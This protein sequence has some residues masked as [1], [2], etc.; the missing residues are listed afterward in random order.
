MFNFI[1]RNLVTTVLLFALGVKAQQNYSIP[2]MPKSPNVAA[3]DRYGTFGVNFYRGLPEISIP[4]YEIKTKSFS[5]P[6]TLSYHASGIKVNDVAS[7]VGL[8]W[9]VSGGAYIGR[10]VRG[11]AD[12]VSSGFTNRNYFLTPVS[13]IDPTTPVGYNYLKALFNMNDP[14]PEPDAFTYNIPG[15]FGHFFYKDHLSDAVFIPQAQLKI[16]RYPNVNPYSYT[17]IDDNGNKYFFGNLNTLDIEYS[18]VQNG[19]TSNSYASTY[20]V[21]KMISADEKDS[22]RYTYNAAN[23]VQLSVETDDYAVIQDNFTAAVGGASVPGSSVTE[24]YTNVTRSSEQKLLQ[25]IEYENGKIEFVLSAQNR[26]D[27]SSKLLDKINIYEKSKSGYVLLKIIDF[28]YGYFSGTNNTKRLRLDSVSVLPASGLEKQVYRFTYNENEPLPAIGLSKSIDYWGYYNGKPNITLMPGR[29]VQYQTA[30]GDGTYVRIGGMPGG[31]DPDPTKVQLGILNR[32]QYPTGGYSI[33][34]YEPNYYQGGGNIN[35]GGGVRIKSI[36]SYDGVG[37]VPIVKS[38]RYGVVEGDESGSGLLNSV[39]SLHFPEIIT[40]VDHIIQIPQTTSF[41]LDYTYRSRY[42]PS[43]PRL[44]NKVF[45]ETNVYYPFVTEYYGNPGNNIGK[46]TYQYSEAND[47]IVTNLFDK[48]RFVNTRHWL[49]GKLLFQKTYKRL[50][51]GLFA[52]LKEIYNQYNIIKDTTYANVG[53]LIAQIARREGVFFEPAE[54]GHFGNLALPYQ[55]S[56]YDMYTG[57]YAVTKSVEKE[58][59]DNGSELVKETYYKYNKQGYIKELKTLN[60]GKDTLYKIFQYPSDFNTSVAVGNDA[61]GVKKLVQIN[62]LNAPIE[63]ITGT[64]KPGGALK[65]K[66]GTLKT[67]YP[68][69][70]NLKSEYLIET[71]APIENYIPS[72]INA[73]GELVISQN[74]KKRITYE[75][76]DDRN[77]LTQYSL[78]GSGQNNSIIWGYNKALLTSD[79]QNAT[80]SQVAFSAFE[81]N[82]KGNWVYDEAYVQNVPT[83]AMSGTYTYVFNGSNSITKSAVPTGKYR[84]SYWSQNACTV[85]GSSPTVTNPPTASGLILYEHIINLPSTGSVTVSAPA[86]T[87]I[88]NLKLEPEKSLSRNFSYLPATGL[89]SE[90]S[91][92]NTVTKY[93]Y[94]GLQQLQQISDQN[95]YVLKKFEYVLN[96]SSPLG[97][98][99]I[100]Y[101]NTIQSTTLRRNNCASTENGQ[102]VTYVVPEQ[103]YFSFLNVNDA[104]QKAIEDLTQNAQLFANAKGLCTSKTAESWMPLT[105]TCQLK[106]VDYL[107]SPTSGHS[108]YVSSVDGTTNYTQVQISRSDNQFKVKID[109][110]IYFTNTGNKIY[111][112]MWMEAG[113]TTKS[114]TIGLTP[115]T[116]EYRNG[117]GI[118]KVQRLSES[119]LTGWMV[120]GRRAKTVGGDIVLVEPNLNGSGTGPYFPPVEGSIYQCNAKADVIDPEINLGNAAYSSLAREVQ[121]KSSCG[122][123]IWYSVP[124]GKYTSTISQEDADQKATNEINTSGQAYANST[125]N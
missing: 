83:A 65:I 125:C 20:L 2:A 28:Y 107:P 24:A 69:V 71:T 92:N 115:Y 4:L 78:E 12:E 60:S 117:A 79:F 21:S 87:K 123:F 112:S 72:Y 23:G 15:K 70:Q 13:Q 62:M 43:Q 58:Y 25:K 91:Q 101:Y 118:T 46:I 108:I 106:V 38:Y 40:P 53:F 67:F 51:S 95:N 45:D 54:T 120:Y 76:Y 6:L 102:K 37:N 96:P 116:N 8:G 103:T 41:I 9:S 77:N 56:F 3:M 85:N 82:D 50:S 89:T 33:F 113:E 64:K 52:P 29:M 36:L 73:S 124:A 74:L 98:I 27:L 119:V 109:Y 7:W 114:A 59:Q 22:I 84:V 14:D 63:T 68:S 30:P 31:R 80:L 61:L 16:G 26:E 122:T 66:S 42:L 35:L 57:M 121:F 86:N 11:T 17:L 48:T 75:L 94:N 100:I 32:I 81:D 110:E 39:N 97:A 47:D 88:D 18:I 34:L 111:G 93:Q 1:K 55:Y 19:G 90:S 99:P 5:I 10:S 104:N 44:D 105:Q 49:R